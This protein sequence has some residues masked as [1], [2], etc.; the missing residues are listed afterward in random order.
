M[1]LI[2][3]IRCKDGVV[4]GSD[5]KTIRGGELSYDNKI[6]EFD[7]GGK[8]LFAAE[9]L[10]GIR[11]DFFLLLTDA[12]KRRRGV[13]TLY[14]LKVG[15]EGII[16]ELTSTYTE[17]IGQEKPIGVLMAGLEYISKGKSILYY[18]HPEGYGEKISFRCSGHGGEYAYSI[19]KFLCGPEI[20]RNLLS[21]EIA[22]RMAFT[23]YWVSE[24]IDT[25]V[26]GFPQI[27][28]IRDDNPETEPIKEEMLREMETKVEALRSKLPMAL[29]FED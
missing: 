8:I 12:I 2:M 26:G 4:I 14:E 17:R 15:V 18:V 19:A 28:I 5:R 27:N 22:K 13:D 21:D 11:D 1:T 23:I 9:G 10:T 16:S 7:V 3:G 29:G 20:S 6:F 25:T 24:K